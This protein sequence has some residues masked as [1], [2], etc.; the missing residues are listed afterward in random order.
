MPR[1]VIRTMCQRAWGGWDARVHNHLVREAM[2]VRMQEGIVPPMIVVVQN[3]KEG[4]RKGWR[5][6]RLIK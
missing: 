3:T 2:W 4:M 5:M 6:T 1:W